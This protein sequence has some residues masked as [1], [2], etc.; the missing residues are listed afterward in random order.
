MGRNYISDALF[1]DA[2]KLYKVKAILYLLIG[3]VHMIF[4][5]QLPNPVLAAVI[6]V[7]CFALGIIFVRR[8]MKEA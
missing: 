5:P 8:R 3:A 7:A 1:V 2:M 4:W 6:G